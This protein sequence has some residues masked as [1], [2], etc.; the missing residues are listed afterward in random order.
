[1]EE[2]LPNELVISEDL[3]LDYINRRGSIEKLFTKHFKKPKKREFS[4]DREGLVEKLSHYNREIGAPEPV[5]RNIKSLSDPHTYAVVTGQQ[6]GILS[7]PLYT[8]YKSISAISTCERLSNEKYSFVPIFWNASEDHDI[9]EIDHI[10][11]FEENKPRKITYSCPK[12]NVPFSHMN[13]NKSRVNEMLRTVNEVSPDSEFKDPLLS[14]FEEI[15]AESRKIGEFFSRFMTY[16]LGEYGL[17]MIEPLHLRESMIPIFERMIN[18][19]TQSTEILS[20]TNSKLEELGYS[21]KIHKKSNLC[22]FFI[23]DD[24]EERRRV[25]YDGEFR[26]GGETYSKKGLIHLLQEN[27]NRFSANAVTRSITQDYVIP[28]HAYVAGPNEV[29]YLAQLGGIYEYFSL[30][31]PVIYPRFGA[32]IIENKVQK[33]LDKYQLKIQELRRPEKLLRRVIGREVDY[34]FDDLKRKIMENMEEASGEIESIDKELL[35]PL[36]VANNKIL[37]AIRELE[38]K[39]KSKLKKSDEITKRQITKAHNNLFPHGGL[40]ERYINVL[41]YLIKFGNDFLKTVYDD[42]SEGEFGQHR[43]IRCP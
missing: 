21:P 30:E 13:L 36:S 38:E 27:P 6:P 35:T 11:V 12:K 42:F 2:T 32:T 19:P 20:E 1:M 31:M 34:L 40:Q 33:T 7:G 3:T 29:A 22:N 43:V 15:V 23:L 9:S 26:A 18:N 8:I 10:Y 24:S 16:L 25:L 39:T 4:G 28:T 5:F 17:I 37:K 14:D 41:E